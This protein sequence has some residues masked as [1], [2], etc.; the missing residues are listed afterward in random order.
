M[1]GTDDSQ[2]PL[3]RRTFLELMWWGAVTPV[4]LMFAVLIVLTV[5][6]PS[7]PASLFPDNR[8]PFP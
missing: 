8:R 4:L 3:S 7:T 1:G 5:L 2:N 6:H